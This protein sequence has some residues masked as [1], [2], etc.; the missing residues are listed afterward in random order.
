MNIDTSRQPYG[1]SIKFLERLFMRYLN[2][3][4]LF[5]K[6]QDEIH[7][8]VNNGGL[9]KDTFIGLLN[10]NYFTKDDINEKIERV[11]NS[12]GSLKDLIL[13]GDDLNESFDT[14]LEVG[15]WIEEH[16]EEA[17]KL[18]QQVN[19]IEHVL[20]H[21]VDKKDL[22]GVAT[23][24]WVEKQKYLKEHQSL[25]E[26]AKIE[27]VEKDYATKSEL[28][29]LDEKISKVKNIAKEKILANIENINKNSTS[30]SALEGNLNDFKVECGENFSNLSDYFEDKIDDEIE[31]V[32][33][34]TKT[35]V[36]DQKYLTK[37]SL[38]GY[39]TEEWVE[40]WVEEKEY[41]TKT[42]LEGLQSKFDE[43]VIATDERLTKIK[44]KVK[45]NI[46]KI[47][48]LEQSVNTLKQL[49]TDDGAFIDSTIDTLSQV[50]NWIKEHG[51]DAKDLIE[52]VNGI[53]NTLNIKADK[54][55]IEDV[56]DWV[57]GQNFATTE[58][59][60]DQKYLTNHQSLDGYAKE[61]WV[62]SQN[63]ITRDVL[64]ND[65]Y[66][67]QDWVT[68][69]NYLTTQSL[70]NY[71][72]KDWVN[73]QNYLTQQKLNN[74]ATQDWVNSKN[75]LTN[76]QSLDAYASKDWVTSQNYATNS[77]IDKKIE[78]ILNRLSY[79]EGK[80]ST[81]QTILNIDE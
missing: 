66:A 79:L 13:G 72:S 80:V 41:A 44:N 56:K 45:D 30:I 62:T 70:E 69:K 65:G 71:A 29:D 34:W 51:D 53:T 25:E 22:I 7:E 73:G 11:N 23:Q 64:K 9:D 15:K 16:G 3:K 49:I 21:K 37:E 33:N 35:W 40:N 78:D 18:F 27:W 2:D 8:Y 26:Y 38:E 1:V 75:Y 55:D 46:E 17:G 60:K 48:D 12:I 59:V 6:I 19:E 5:Q 39:A 42:E 58:W 52:T 63:Y 54:S 31:K 47:D 77:D 14:L 61:D 32:R 68:S 20:K 4:K 10:D 81:Y 67:T 74:Y 50:N 57:K 28:N 24:H 36:K 43:N 76:H